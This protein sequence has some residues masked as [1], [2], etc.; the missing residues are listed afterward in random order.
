MRKEW[1]DEDKQ[2]LYVSGGNQAT[3][4]RPLGSLE[5]YPNDQRAMNAEKSRLNGGNDQSN[6]ISAQL[7]SDD[8]LLQQ[9]EEGHESHADREP[10]LSGGEE[11]ARHPGVQYVPE[12]DELDALLKEQEDRGFASTRSVAAGTELESQVSHSGF[13]DELEAMEF[14]VFGAQVT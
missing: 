1:I 13:S 6:E 3:P 11:N 4:Q 2:K 9:R 5:S 14:G 8:T 10:L 7:L 12:D